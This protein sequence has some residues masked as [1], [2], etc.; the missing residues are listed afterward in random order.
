MLRT[1]TPCLEA[2]RCP[3]EALMK[4][5]N[6]EYQSTFARAYVAQ[7]LEE[8]LQKGKLIALFEVLDARGLKVDA[9]ARQRIL[10]LADSTQLRVWLRR[11]VTVD[12][13]QELFEQGPAVKPVARKASKQSR[14]TKARRPRSKR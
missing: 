3:L 8:G 7:G 9:E 10:A 1:W 13:V 12:T 4:I 2:A 11:A 14:G 6:Y 5:G